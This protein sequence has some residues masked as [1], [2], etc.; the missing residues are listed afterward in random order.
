MTNYT[1]H[2]E[3]LVQEAE[4]R[5]L[6]AVKD[7]L[8]EDNIV[9]AV[10]LMECWEAY[11]SIGDSKTYTLEEEVQLFLNKVKM[12]ENLLIQLYSKCNSSEEC[13]NMQDL[14]N[15]CQHIYNS[16][17]EEKSLSAGGRFEWV[18]S[19]L[20]KCLQEGS[21][22][23]VD[24]VN[25]CNAAVLDRLNGLLEPNGTL[26]IS[27]RGMNKEGKM[28]EVK[29]HR[30]FRI[31]LTMDPKNG[32]ISR[33]MRNRG[34]E[35][36]MLNDLEDT[37]SSNQYD[38]KSLVANEGL[39]DPQDI[40][41]LIKIHQ[42]ISSLIVSDKPNH[43]DILR[44]S[45]LIAKQID[46]SIPLDEAFY[47]TCVEVYYKTRT[48]SEF[49]CNNILEVIRD[50]VNRCL[51]ER[52][53]DE[54]D[55]FSKNA[56]ISTRDL[57][58][59]SEYVKTK[60]EMCLYK[61]VMEDFSNNFDIAKKNLYDGVD[62][63]K[64][65][66][67]EY[68][69][70]LSKKDRL[71]ES[72]DLSVW[73]DLEYIKLHTKLLDDI[74]FYKVANLL[75][76]SYMMS[77]TD[78]L[79][80]KTLHLR[81]IVPNKQLDIFLNY[82]SKLVKTCGTTTN[83]L[84]L[85]CRWINKYSHDDEDSFDSINYAFQIELHS[86]RD[87]F[88][89]TYT[90]SRS[91]Y[92]S[93]C[94]GF[95]KTSTKSNRR[96]SESYLLK[97]SLF[98]KYC[99]LRYRYFSFLHQPRFENPPKGADC[100]VKTLDLLSWRQALHSFLTNVYIEWSWDDRDIAR[101]LDTMTVY[102][103]WFYKYSI[104]GISEL[105]S[106]NVPED[107]QTILND[108][109]KEIHYFSRDYKI[110]HAY[111][112][113]NNVPESLKYIWQLSALQVLNS[114]DF[115][116]ACNDISRIICYL[117]QNRDQRHLLQKIKLAVYSPNDKNDDVSAIQNF[118]EQ[119]N[120]KKTDLDES[121][122][123]ILPLGDTMIQ[124][125]LL[126]L[127][128][129]DESTF[130]TDSLNN[131]LIPIELSAALL[132]YK[133]NENTRLT[134][135]IRKGFYSSAVRNASVMPGV[136]LK[137]ETSSSTFLVAGICPM[138]S[139]LL[140]R[141]LDRESI[142]LQNYR[143]VEK[144]RGYVGLLMWKNIY[145]VSDKSNDFLSMQI[146]LV[147]D[148]VNNFLQR[149]EEAEFKI[150]HPSTSKIEGVSSIVNG[151][152]SKLVELMVKL[153]SNI[154]DTED[155]CFE[156]T[157]CRIADLHMLLGYLEGYFNS[158]LPKVDPLAKKAM[159]K[160]HLNSV[161]S[162]FNQMAESYRLT[163][164]LLSN[165]ENCYHPYYQAIRDH[166]KLLEDKVKKYG[167][168]TTSGVKAHPYSYVIQQIR[169]AFDGVLNRKL[170]TDALDNS[171]LEN[172]K[173][174]SDVSEN[175]IQRAVRH[176]ERLETSLPSFDRI[177]H[178]WKTYRCSYPDIVEP[179][180]ANV[181]QLRYG[182]HLKLYWAR[183]ELLKYNHRVRFNLDLEEELVRLVS[184]PALNET[185]TDMGDYID[186]YTHGSINTFIHK[187]LE[188][189]DYVRKKE[190]LRLLKCGI[191]DYFNYN[192]IKAK[193]GGTLD[194]TIMA[195]FNNLL[196]CFVNLWNQQREHEEQEQ[197]KSASLYQIKTKCD[198]KSEHE[199]IDDELN[200]MF[201]NY[202]VSDFAD[203]QDTGLTDSPPSPP[204][205]IPDSVKAITE[206]DIQ[207]V[208]DLHSILLNNFTKSEWISLKFDKNIVPDFTTPLL[209]RFKIARL[210]TDEYSSN[211]KYTTDL[212][213]FG[214][215]SVLLDG[216]RRFLV[217]EIDCTANTN[218]DFYKD[219]DVEEVKNCYHV[220][221]E[222][223]AKVKELLM[224]WPDQPTLNTILTVID[225]IVNFDITSPLSRFLTGFDVLLQ[226]CH[227]WEQ[228]AHSGISL[229]HFSPNLTQQIISWRKI[230][231]NRWKDLLNSTFQDMKKSVRKWWIYM[232]NLMTQYTA[233]E[234]VSEADLI[235]IL[236]KFI[237][238]SPLAEFDSRL[239][240]IFTFHL[241]AIFLTKTTRTE[242][243]INI[244]WNV[245]HYFT[246]FSSTIAQK[247]KDVRMPIEKKLR[248]YVKIVR[249]KDV[250]YWSIKDTVDKTHKAL[251]KSVRE[252]KEAMLQPVTTYLYS[253]SAENSIE[254]IGVWDR[255][256]RQNPK[257]YHYTLDPDSYLIKAPNKDVPFLA[258]ARKICKEAISGTEYPLL[259]KTLDGFIT[260]VIETSSHLRNLEVDRSLPKEKQ[261][262]QAKSVLQQKHRA[263]ADLFQALSKMGLSYK[264]G[265]VDV[266]LKRACENFTTS[267]VNLAASFDHLMHNRL[268]E[269][270]LTVWDSCEIYYYKCL[271]RFDILERSLVN[272]AKDLGMPNIERCRGFATELLTYCQYQKKNLTQSTR[273][274]YYLRSYSRLI[275]ETCHNSDYI[276]VEDLTEIQEAI[277]STCI[278]TT[279]IKTILES[280]LT[281]QSM[282]SYLIDIPT[283][284]PTYNKIRYRNDDSWQSAMKDVD[285]IH[286]AVKRLSTQLR[287]TE[288]KLPCVEHVPVQ[289]RFLPQNNR[290]QMFDD[291]RTLREHLSGLRVVMYPISVTNTIDWLIKTFDKIMEKND[292]NVED[293]HITNAD[294]ILQESSDSILISIQNIYKKYRGLN[295]NKSFD[296]DTDEAIR[297]N[298]LK[299]LIMENLASDVSSL[300]LNNILKHVEELIKVLLGDAAQ[301]TERLKSMAAQYLPLLDQVLQLT[302][303][304]ITQQVCAYRTTCK[305]T[306][307]ILNIFNDLSTKGFCIPPELSEEIDK[308]GISKPSDGMGLGEGQGERDVSDKIESEDQLDD[309]QPAGQEKENNEDPDCKEEDKGIEMSEDFDSKLQD[310]KPNSDSSDEE[311]DNS[312]ADEQMGETEKGADQVD[313]E[314]WGDKDDNQDEDESEENKDDGTGG[315]K[316]GEDQLGA[317]NENSKDKQKKQPDKEQG[318]SSEKKDDINEMKEPEYD[319][320]Q[321]DPYHGNQPELPE[322]EPMDLPDDL[323]LDE[324]E[325]N[326]GEKAEENPFDIDENKD[327]MEEMPKDTGEDDRPDK[328]SDEVDEFSSDEEDTK[329][330]NEN[331]DREQVEKDE[332][333][334]QDQN[335]GK[336]MENE[337]AEEDPEASE[338]NQE[339][340]LDENVTNQENVEA[341]E[342]DDAQATDKTQASNSEN[343]KSNQP[344][345]ELNQE[346]RPDK[347]GVGQSQMEESDT[348]HSAQTSAADQV[349]GSN[350]EEE[351]PQK[352][353][354]K[355]GVSDSKRSLGDVDQPVQ[356]RLKTIDSQT[357]STDRDEQDDDRAQMY[358]HI[359]DASEKTKTQTLDTAT[360]EQAEEQ[361]KTVEPGEE[362]ED[363]DENI[364]GSEN[365]PEEDEAMDVDVA[366][367]R[368]DLAAKTEA[369]KEIIKNKAQ[370][371]EGD[372]VDDVK[373]TEI[374]GEIVPTNTVPR[375]DESS[376]HTQF[377]LLKTYDGNIDEEIN[378]RRK[379]V[380][381]QLS[382]WKTSPVSAEAEV[383]W[384]RISSITSTLAQELSEK[385]RLILEPTQA[386]RLKGD[387]RTGRRINMRRIIPYIASQFRKDKIWMRRTKASKREY[388]IVL[389]I[390]D[391]SSMADN[392][393][394]EMAFECVSLIS[395]ALTLLESGQLAVVG[396]GETTE[397]HHKLTEP[398]TENSGAHLLQKFQ[399]NQQ[400]TCVGELMSF[401]TEMFAQQ[402]APASVATA[403][404]LLIVSD[405]RGVFSEG[406]TF[407]TRAVRRA[408]LQNINT[409]CIIIDSPENKNSILDIRTTVFKDGKFY[410]IQNYMDEFPFAFYIIL[411]DVNT[412]PRVLS[413][414][415]RQWFEIVTSEF[416]I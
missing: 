286:S 347:D 299:S 101:K 148:H 60:F 132:D 127:M 146:K 376:Y 305:L 175:R 151:S 198:D 189:G 90:D 289:V 291:V 267:P 249:W 124:M 238:K 197:Q 365:V 337:P 40:N 223:K 88:E 285:E 36:Y 120:D 152:V 336:D 295:L 215:L 33:A 398:F 319:E 368:K 303:Y 167:D 329:N 312:D 363:D 27:E 315:E 298:H 211:F 21:W 187:V 130:K 206:D 134:H 403:K 256:Q 397:V 30:D 14:L 317:K 225:R 407:V 356:K 183:R 179:L 29:P 137:E 57:P 333:M 72:K 66:A 3:E 276:T 108:I 141:L 7:L 20:V 324:G 47:T 242:S 202:H 344:I 126:R 39:S 154:G 275:H 416:T 102:Y 351:V 400:K 237:S 136:F 26:T 404:L 385:L 210:I 15:R 170:I 273:S 259:V 293:R 362:T 25:L 24:N 381:E 105:L 352:K 402:G 260:D 131:T 176:I 393:S 153:T 335:K 390:D 281:E 63:T 334:E 6:V 412:L 375:G 308:E 103:K 205:I 283:I 186:N 321:V 160:N 8:L 84:P 185:T 209:E 252:F 178:E 399:F 355:P 323:Q 67:N 48:S 123:Q 55:L 245:Y 357:E 5:T 116:D 254:S 255:P 143:T 304:F 93:V 97:N 122:M 107:F 165:Y 43:T 349:K 182:L 353:K 135:E 128:A 382:S 318:E 86:L 98:S 350:M 87:E 339:S 172:L 246:Q 13:V 290:A 129:Y 1:R 330:D 173:S 194:K 338:E 258:R 2:L 230:E 316:D 119:D 247:V 121:V 96:I 199:Q 114:Y 46:H 106:L 296:K 79:E 326:D 62:K 9:N 269:K 406:K 144:Q 49:N 68:I 378:N 232:Y 115:S 361:K 196:T 389:A 221:D 133:N 214:S 44:C 94:L 270:I 188:K 386:S 218:K 358:E 17:N 346:D 83:R 177:I 228:V 118:N 166:V 81:N 171:L 328:Q 28:F 64:V 216:V 380:E 220:L 287:K 234:K 41:T 181:A 311:S 32:E 271:A 99:D 190:Y 35:I 342:T 250:N 50:G 213:L 139:Y 70:T 235:D 52:A 387:Y 74:D 161:I 157:I 10:K 301:P 325:E 18:N 408:Q 264:K 413:D 162:M 415:L 117:V 219:A 300:D 112:K 212:S 401:V 111:R 288:N 71:L 208:I 383:A 405:G 292:G 272:P 391:S 155:E 75:I 384:Q 78:N 314:I 95:Q 109:N 229:I 147:Q 374:E 31:F 414:A 91:L 77:S 310:K 241:H 51:D 244:L 204:E 297:E 306:S 150:G 184:F 145:A 113:L 280:C 58:R 360:R 266:K 192:V 45:S 191:Q 54:R 396:F 138:Y 42:F 411:R 359:K 65:T 233:E 53:T 367:S 394:K 110:F 262:S 313:Q 278:V 159:K 200:E 22:L 174:L 371:P 248:E 158:A 307:V 257:A 410:G 38:L 56:T 373:E 294:T 332:I 92:K 203:L 379:E 354:E 388:Q 377:E 263:L 364:E 240:L 85:D 193:N 168:G 34:I 277:N 392:H 253:P 156:D 76:N 217:A 11:L 331:L 180:L 261:V 37:T 61:K 12:I 140:N 100:F 243:F 169:H 322:P 226:K 195:K 366:E 19:V 164:N 369:N 251:H 274:Y 395:K 320:Q 372:I 227:E 348:G 142:T 309:A 80:H 341:M 224:E 207:Y 82:F 279:Q 69:D 149:L 327:S 59:W 23:L 282:E 265:V 343:M 370:H 302:H 409:V 284:E 73:S 16:V 222:L 239:N 345:D 125:M 236:E 268:D 89:S 340:G 231:L 104:K 201:T 4:R 163:A